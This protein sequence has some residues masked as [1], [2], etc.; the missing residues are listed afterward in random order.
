MPI[1]VETDE[2]KGDIVDSLL[3][4]QQHA[5]ITAKERHGHEGNVDAA[6]EQDCQQVYRHD[7]RAG[8]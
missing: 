7:H 3:H 1:S 8:E 2:G 5:D 4:H 6:G